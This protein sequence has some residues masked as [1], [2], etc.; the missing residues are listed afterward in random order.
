VDQ[1]GGNDRQWEWKAAGE[2]DT[3]DRVALNTRAVDWHSDANIPLAASGIALHADRA[4]AAV[5]NSFPAHLRASGSLRAPAGYERYASAPVESIEVTGLRVEMYDVVDSE[6][7]QFMANGMIVHNS[8]ADM[9][10]LA[11]I[12][13]RSA[14]KD[15]DAR[16]VNTVHDEIVV[17]VREDQAEEVKHIVEHAMVAAGQTILKVVPIVAEASVADYWSK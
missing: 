6:T 2:I 14:L 8:N 7:G 10:K 12:N 13:L 9:T 17:E 16:V 5:G 11:L 1:L 4:G 15:W 3:G